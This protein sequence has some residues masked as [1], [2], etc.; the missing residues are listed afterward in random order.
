MKVASFN[1]NGIRARLSVILDWLAKESPDVLCIQETKV[2]DSEFPGKPFEEAGYYSVY[3]GGKAYNGVAMVSRI[4]LSNI[5]FGFSD[6]DAGEETR[7]V[8][9]TFLEV[10]IVNTYVPQGLAPDSE[11]FRYKLDWF[12]RLR[13]HFSRHF[14]CARPLLWVGDFNVAPEPI[15]VCDPTNM[16]GSIG[17]HPDEQAALAAVKSWGFIDVFRKHEPGTGKFTFWDYRVPNA[18]KRGLGWRI[19]HI[20]ATPVLAAR[21]VRAWIDIAP[22]LVPKPSDHTFVAAE[23]DL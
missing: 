12:H 13:D 4:A 3:R 19:D 21:S 20:W 2:Q 8:C 5:C 23:F 16:V 18:V 14:D 10:P 9:G 6:G 15:D 11:K 1:A 22:R 7:L 17:F